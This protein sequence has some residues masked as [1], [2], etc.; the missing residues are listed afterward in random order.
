[1]LW[2]GGSHDGGQGLAHLSFADPQVLSLRNSDYFTLRH[3]RKLSLCRLTRFLAAGKPDLAYRKVAQHT[4]DWSGGTRIGSALD[5]F[6]REHG[7]R[8]VARGA[9]VVGIGTVLADDPQLTVRRV[10]GPSPTRVIL[11]P[12][13]KL[14]MMADDVAGPNGLAF[15]PDEKLLYVV[16]SRA[17]PHRTIVAFDVQDGGKKL[18]KSKVLIDAGP[19]GSPDG[20]RVD[21]HGNLWCGWG[22]GSAELDGVRIFN[23]DGKPIG[24]IDLPER[25]ANVCFGG[26]YRNRLFMAASHSLY[27]LYV[28]TQGVAGG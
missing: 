17:E 21:I 3:G 1:M 11:D 24:H 12:K 4:P 10:P 20:F 5:T 26:R 8:G 28:N 22:M 15:S 16:A 19:G 6:I 13:G 25:C 14:H 7:Q 23:K 2:P 18:G 27:A 9:V